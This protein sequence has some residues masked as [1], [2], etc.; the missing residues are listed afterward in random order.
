MSIRF[1]V[2]RLVGAVLQVCAVRTVALASVLMGVLMGALAG[3]LFTAATAAAQTPP[4]AREVAAFKPLLK[5]AYNNDVA[6]IKTLLAN[7]AA[8]NAQDSMERT[9]VHI[10]AYR[11]HELALRQLVAGGAD[12]NAMEGDA[13]DAVTI[14]AV[15]NDLAL[16]K[17]ALK[18]GGNAGAVT[19]PY[20]GTALIAAAHLAHVAVVEVLIKAGAP[21]DHINNLGWTALMEAIVLGNGGARH[22]ATV[23]ALL[24]AGADKSIADRDGVSPLQHARA[25]FG[26][27][28]LC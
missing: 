4:S 24:A 25:G 7:G 15:A 22:V 18:L 5:A 3:L 16:L 1:Q 20:D 11:S 28:P 14:A 17:L 13:Y 2:L 6:A 27:L 9:A 21:L 19:S 12:I 8:P 10:A 23:R 26:T